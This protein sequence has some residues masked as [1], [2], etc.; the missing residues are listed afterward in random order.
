MIRQII[1]AIYLSV[2]VSSCAAAK[3]KIH[4]VNLEKRVWRICSSHLDGLE[5]HEKGFCYISQECKKSA[6]SNKCRPK[7]LFCEWGDIPCLRH[8]KLLQK[9]LR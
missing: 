9:K 3:W 8:Y 6:F 1:L 5:K 4:D 7:P 2:I